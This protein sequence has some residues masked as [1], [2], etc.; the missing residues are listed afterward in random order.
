MGMFD[1]LKRELPPRKPSQ[2]P[3]SRLQHLVLNWANGGKPAVSSTNALVA[4][5]ALQNPVIYRVV[6]KIAESV[7]AVDWYAEP[8]PNVSRRKRP[9][10]A[11]IADINELLSSPNDQ[12]SGAQMRYW[13]ALSFAMYSKIHLKVGVYDGK[14]NGI[15][16]LRSDKAKIISSQGAIKGWSYGDSGKEEKLPSHRYASRSGDG[17]INESFAFEIAKPNLFATPGESLSALPSIIK[18][19]TIIDNLFQRALETSSG[20]P[21]SKYIITS[22][23]GLTSAQESDINSQIKDRETGGDSSG[24]VLYLWGTEVKVEKLDNDLSDLHSKIPAD[25]MARHIAGAWGVPVALVGFAG[26]DGSKFANNYTESR[27]SFYEDTLI[28]G[29]LVPIAEE[30]TRNICP[31]GVR[32]RFDYDTIPALREVR[33]KSAREASSI[34]FIDENEKRELTGFLPSVNQDSVD[35]NKP[36]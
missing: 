6:N 27:R 33:I 26:A 23:K 25:D 15:Y 34:S 18:P 35:E 24:N 28:P 1:F 3:V 8:D 19:A 2:D 10:K 31:S 29:Y 4:T 16:P 12:M 7:Q 11:T 30:F 5:I 13:L 36:E 14:A 22:E 17:A 9:G 20:H 21:N 32:I